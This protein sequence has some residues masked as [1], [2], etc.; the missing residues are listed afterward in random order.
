ME[1]LVDIE[2]ELDGGD[3]EDDEDDSEDDSSSGSGHGSGSDEE[4]SEGQQHEQ[5]RRG[6]RLHMVRQAGVG[7]GGWR[8]TAHK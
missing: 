8:L 6:C 3:D 4:M 2:V 7:L 1:Q 5:V